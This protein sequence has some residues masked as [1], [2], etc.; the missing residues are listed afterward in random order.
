[1]HSNHHPQPLFCKPVT[2]DQILWS[3]FYAAVKGTIQFQA[4]NLKT[5]L[6]TIFDWVNQEYALQYWQMNGQYSQLLSI[7][8]C[9]EFNPY[10]QSFVGYF[11]GQM[12]CQFDLYSIAVDELK[13]HIEYKQNDCGFHLIMAPVKTPVPGLTSS[14][15]RAFL[16]YYFSSSNA[17][18]MYAEPDVY[19]LKSVQLLEKAGFKKMATVTMSYKTAHIYK[20][21]RNNP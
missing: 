19:N 1:M 14:I 8:Q 18:C 4:L 11:N 5:D 12:V 13:D 6:P 7:Y 2:Q 15:I 9:M 3:K 21:N 17:D 20:L 10:A 16:E